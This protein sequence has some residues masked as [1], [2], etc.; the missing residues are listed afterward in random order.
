MGNPDKYSDHKIIDK[1]NSGYWFHFDGQFCDVW[2]LIKQKYPHIKGMKDTA[3]ATLNT[4][5]LV[6]LYSDDLATTFT[7]HC[8]SVPEKIKKLKC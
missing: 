1:P 7:A 6:L 2:Y 5:N 3:S 8:E 4:V